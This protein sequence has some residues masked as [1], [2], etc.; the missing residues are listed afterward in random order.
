MIHTFFITATL[1]YLSIG[2]LL[3][4]PLLGIFIVNHAPDSQT[5]KYMGMMS[6][7]FSLAF[8]LGPSAGSWKYDNY[9]GSTL[10]FSTG[11]MGIMILTGFR[12]L[13]NM[14]SKKK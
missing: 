10:W 13:N 6:L 7:T 4:F 11:V 12:W 9:G 2:E 1:V 14:V 8:V 3:T 5:G